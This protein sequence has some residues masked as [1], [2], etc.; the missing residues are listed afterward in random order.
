MSRLLSPA[1]ECLE[2][3]V[4]LC[5]IRKISKLGC[6]ADTGHVTPAPYSYFSM[7]ES[8]KHNCQL[9]ERYSEVERGPTFPDDQAVRVLQAVP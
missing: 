2:E 3:G 6:T 4:Y 8:H 5:S 1:E 9:Q 7:P